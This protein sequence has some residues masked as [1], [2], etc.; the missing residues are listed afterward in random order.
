MHYVCLEHTLVHVNDSILADA[1]VR[2]LRFFMI[3]I[4]LNN[5]YGIEVSQILLASILK[6]KSLVPGVY[7]SISTTADALR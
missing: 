4:K 5:I 3:I 1:L 2:S 6:R 7:R